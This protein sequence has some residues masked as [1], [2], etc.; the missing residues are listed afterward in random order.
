MPGSSSRMTPLRGMYTFPTGDSV[1]IWVPSNSDPSPSVKLTDTPS[2]EGVHHVLL[3]S[4]S[5]TMSENP[6][7]FM[8]SIAASLSFIFMLTV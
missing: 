7:F 6:S 4:V 8:Y 2:R 5:S 3:L 1:H